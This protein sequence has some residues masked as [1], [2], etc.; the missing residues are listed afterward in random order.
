MAR[1]IFLDTETTGRRPPDHRVIE[2]GAVEFT[3][4]M[5]TEN[6]FHHYINPLRDIDIKAYEVHK[7]SL[8]QL[9]DKPTF[10][11]IAQDLIEFC[12]GAEVIMHN[13]SFDEGF[14]NS[15]FKHCGIDVQMKDFC[16]VTDSIKVARKLYRFNSYSLDN[17]CD[18]FEIS[19]AHRTAHGAL[20][21]ANL[22]ADLYIKMTASQETLMLDNHKEEFGANESKSGNYCTKVIRPSV[23]EKTLLAEFKKKLKL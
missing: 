2:I 21:D 13:A 17:L 23:D 10:D 8:D 11:K 1:Q 22:L 3:Q 7:I 20:L 12:T 4:R 18:K 15:E 5:R 6:T 14:I 16:K 19:R 9:K